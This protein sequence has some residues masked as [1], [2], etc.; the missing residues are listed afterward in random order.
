MAQASNPDGDDLDQT[1]HRPTWPTCKAG[2]VKALDPEN[3]TLVWKFVEPSLTI[4]IWTLTALVTTG[5]LWFVLSRRTK[6]FA[7][8]KKLELLGVLKQQLAELDAGLANRTLALEQYDQSRMEL[9]RRLLSEAGTATYAPAASSASR[10]IPPATIALLVILTVT[11]GY[12]LAG[13]PWL[14]RTPMTTP[15]SAI[16]ANPKIMQEMHDRVARLAANPKDA[17][18]WAMLGR[19]YSAQQRFGE[20]AEAFAKAEALQPGNAE[21]LAD[22]ADALAMAQGRKFAGKPSELVQRALQADPTNLKALSLAGSVAFDAGAYGPAIGFWQQ[23]LQQVAPAS[24]MASTARANIA[25]AQQRA[26]RDAVAARPGKSASASSTRGPVPAHALATITGRVRLIAELSAKASPTD[27]VFVFA[28]ATDGAT[29]PL[30]LLKRQV[31]DL[32]MDF[33]LDD[34][35]ALSPEAKLSK[36][37]LVDVGAR[38]SKS[39]SVTTQRGDLVSPMVRTLVGGPDVQVPIRGLVR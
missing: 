17:D 32:P 22:Y 26:G 4:I 30:A 28:R 15:E 9:E 27:T 8:A 10:L 29:M 38:I 18:G 39:G 36:F 1:Q 34:T 2:Q 20:S 21:L 19:A 16:A 31:K 37:K 13:K 12:F 14:T 3:Q 7:P 35:M 33:M 6:V 25:E 5:T 24:E 11:G 23:L